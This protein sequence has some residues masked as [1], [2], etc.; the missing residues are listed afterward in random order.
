MEAGAPVFVVLIGGASVASLVPCSSTARSCLTKVGRGQ[1]TK[2]RAV[3]NL[4]IKHQAAMAGEDARRAELSALYTA[5]VRLQTALKRKQEYEEAQASSEDAHPSTSATE[6]TLSSNAG[7]SLPST[8]LL[9]PSSP[10]LSAGA[11]AEN[12]ALAKEAQEAFL[13]L[14]DLVDGKGTLI[15]CTSPFFPMSMCL[16]AST[17]SLL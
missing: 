2:K 4:F 3:S 10:A 9:S 8:P 16:H 11:A 1:V 13:G 12:L 15:P 17:K 5:Y 14:I 7:V 6:A